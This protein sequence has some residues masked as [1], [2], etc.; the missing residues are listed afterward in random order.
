MK[1]Y[2]MLAAWEPNS[3]F[4]LIE[5]F[6]FSFKSCSQTSSFEALI[7]LSICSV[8]NSSAL[9]FFSLI[10]SSDSSFN[11][12]SPFVFWNSS[13]S[14]SCSSLVISLNFWTTTAISSSPKCCFI[15]STKASFRVFSAYFLN[16]TEFLYCL[17]YLILSALEI[18]LHSWT[19]LWTC[20][21]NSES[22]WSIF[23]ISATSASVPFAS[24]AFLR[25]SNNFT[26]LFIPASLLDNRFRSFE[27][28]TTA[29]AD[30][31]SN[32]PN[33]LLSKTFSNS[34]SP[35]NISLTWET[36][37]WSFLPNKA[38]FLAACKGAIATPFL[39]LDAFCSSSILKNSARADCISPLFCL[40]RRLSFP[41]LLTSVIDCMKEEY[42][43]SFVWV[44]L[45]CNLVETAPWSFA[46]LLLFTYLSIIDTNS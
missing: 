14:A 19:I 43:V 37:N 30:K 25:I 41:S 26:C 12:A 2:N 38:F 13:L 7:K 36:V 40:K 34:F 24:I 33:I 15:N 1:L 4:I 18:F 35:N 10:L 3:L 17:T 11:K 21:Y 8:S 42:L 46:S 31:N 27:V 23:A 22:C 29:F 6:S 28:V 9:L 45:C 44:T 39:A 32:I 16:K 5:Y 20:S